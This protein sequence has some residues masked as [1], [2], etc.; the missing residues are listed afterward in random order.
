MI[1]LRSS[2]IHQVPFVV[3][4]T[5]GNIIALSGSC[6]LQGPKNQAKK[7]FHETRRWSAVAYLSSLILTLVFAFAPFP[8]PGWKWLLLMVLLIIQYAAVAW[9]CL[10][11]I[12]FARDAISSWCTRFVSTE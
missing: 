7:M 12:P 5:V 6:F 1:K 4:C 8:G 2:F 10:S 11:Y 9:Y 3:N